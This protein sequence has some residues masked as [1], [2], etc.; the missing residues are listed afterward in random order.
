MFMI[1][2][3]APTKVGKIMVEINLS[4]RLKP[5]AKNLDCFANARKDKNIGVY[6]CFIGG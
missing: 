5:V 3:M 6:R 4:H 1:E 2:D